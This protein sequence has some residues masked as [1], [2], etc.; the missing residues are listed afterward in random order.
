MELDSWKT[1]M[2]RPL[3]KL[4]R[5]LG[6]ARAS[7]RSPFP[8]PAGPRPPRASRY[9]LH[10]I[11]QRKTKP[12]PNENKPFR[13]LSPGSGRWKGLCPGRE[14]AASPRCRGPRSLLRLPRGVGP[15]VPCSPRAE[16]EK[17]CLSFP[18]PP[19]APFQEKEQQQEPRGR[20]LSF[21]QGAPLF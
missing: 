6:G 5:R 9:I 17:T 16:A 13:F 14:S 7:S 1:E 8:S 3:H 10:K 19:R 11:M 15:A 4:Q 18:P 20:P 21:R 2:K 12:K